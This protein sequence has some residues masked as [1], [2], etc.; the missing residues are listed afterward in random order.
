MRVSQVDRRGRDKL[1]RPG[2]QDDPVGVI[3]GPVGGFHRSK[4]VSLLN[5]YRA[6]YFQFFG[7][8]TQGHFALVL[9]AVRGSETSPPA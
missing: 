9:T 1:G 2:R 4:Y 3:S 5:L 8:E 6:S 7:L